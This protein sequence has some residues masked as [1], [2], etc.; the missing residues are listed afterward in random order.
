MARYA[1]FEDDIFGIRD[2]TTVGLLG[3]LLFD[4]RDCKTRPDA[5]LL[6]ELVAEPFNEFDYGN[7]DGP[8]HGRG[9]HLSRPSATKT[10]WSWQ[11]G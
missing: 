1:Q 4:N 6:A 9:P 2:F 7:F 5:R 8:L 11:G 10:R 3:G